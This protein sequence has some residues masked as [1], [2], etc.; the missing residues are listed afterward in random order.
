MS[1]GEQISEAYA[2]HRA[3]G[4]PVRKGQFARYV[5]NPST[6]DV[7]MTNHV[8]APRAAVRADIDTLLFEMDEVFA[9]CSHRLVFLDPLTPPALE[10]R[11]MADGYTELDPTIQMLLSGSL[12]PRATLGDLIL[13]V[14]ET[15]DDWE[16]L[17]RLMK[18]DH[19]EGKRS[20]GMDLEDH[21]TRGLVLDMRRKSGPSTVYLG[22]IGG[23]P[24]AYGSGVDCPGGL[25]MIED[26]FTLPNYR[27][28]GIASA[29]I[30]GAIDHLRA[31]NKERPIFLGA[32]AR[33]GA[34]NLYRELGFEPVLVSR[35][36]IRNA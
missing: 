31:Q 1:I 23:K 33:E 20:F 13:S 29:L 24:V 7:W 18:A 22:W 11:L 10:A 25:G 4:N 12:T 27:G 3:L 8:Q 36:L 30:G 14:I 6:P 26:I 21:V 15:D 32:L 9:H 28:L 34:K 5:V 35:E 16:D 17:Y 19:A 2:W